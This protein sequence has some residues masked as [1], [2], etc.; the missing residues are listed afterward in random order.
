[1]AGAARSEFTVK[2]VSKIKRRKAD[3]LALLSGELSDASLPVPLFCAA[4]LR[5]YRQLGI[6]VQPLMASASTR[7]ARIRDQFAF[8]TQQLIFTGKTFVSGRRACARASAHPL[9]K[10]PTRSHLA[11]ARAQE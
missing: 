7:T 11:C 2:Q 9:R 3:G 8:G 10:F 1:M 5:N 4:M 6:E